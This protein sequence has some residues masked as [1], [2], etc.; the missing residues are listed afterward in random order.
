M[1]EEQAGQ[2]AYFIGPSLISN[3]VGVLLPGEQ[4]G[5]LASSAPDGSGH[6][7]VACTKEIFR[8]VPSKPGEFRAAAL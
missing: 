8:L 2:F 3:K 5:G 4:T 1:G 6:G 7:D